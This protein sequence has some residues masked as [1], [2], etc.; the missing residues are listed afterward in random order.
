MLKRNTI[1]FNNRYLSQYDDEYID[2]LHALK[3]R[4]FNTFNIDVDEYDIVWVFADDVTASE[5]LI[6]SLK[7]KIRTCSFDRY[8]PAPDRVMHIKNKLM[9]EER[10]A[11]SHYI[12]YGSMYNPFSGYVKEPDKMKR[13]VYVDKNKNNVVR[14]KNV[15]LDCCDSFP[16]IDVPENVTAWV[17]TTGTLFKCQSPVSFIVYKKNIF[18]QIRHTYKPYSVLD[19]DSLIRYQTKEYFK[20]HA[21]TANLYGLF[22][23]YNTIKDYDIQ[24][25]RN[26][27]DGIR[28]RIISSYPDLFCGSGPV[29]VLKNKYLFSRI[30]AD[31]NIYRSRGKYLLYL[32]E[33]DDGNLQPFL[34]I[35]GKAVNEM[36]SDKYAEDVKFKNK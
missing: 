32:Y 23:F 26:R 19:L 5:I 18:K 11:G 22:E 21:Q 10:W 28:N 34:D 25:M 4:F 1:Y 35:I 3:T 36:E 13:E 20:N 27:I 29:L 9:Q 16:Y 6:N 12:I 15:Y 31:F 24:G 17:G 8:V 14:Y 7:N 30:I 33:Y 2:F